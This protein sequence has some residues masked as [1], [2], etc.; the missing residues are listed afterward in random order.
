MTAAAVSIGELEKRVEDNSSVRRLRRDRS[1]IALQPLVSDSCD[2][3]G[4]FLAP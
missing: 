4:V 1:L 3:T 2:M